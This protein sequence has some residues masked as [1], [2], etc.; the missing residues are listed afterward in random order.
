MTKKLDTTF[1][2]IVHPAIIHSL[3]K[4]MDIFFKRDRRRLV[5]GGRGVFCLDT[6]S[7]S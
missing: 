5:N 7:A 2:Q 4:D 6:Q 3:K 1:I